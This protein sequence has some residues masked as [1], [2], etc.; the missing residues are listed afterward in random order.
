MYGARGN[1]ADEEVCED[2]WPRATALEDSAEPCEEEAEGKH[3]GPPPPAAAASAA[4]LK[5]GFEEVAVRERVQVEARE[6]EDDVEEL[7]LHGEEELAR[8]VEGHLAVVVGG[9]EGL[10]E[11]R[12]DGEEGEVLDIGVAV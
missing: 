1:V 7:V 10:E 6:G 12:G 11:N 8:G 3:L 9:P 2:V 4:G 5:G